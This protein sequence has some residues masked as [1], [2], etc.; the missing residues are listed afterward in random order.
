MA[1]TQSETNS[2]QQP[3]SQAA[4]MEMDYN[5]A[6]ELAFADENPF[7]ESPE[8]AAL[9]PNSDKEELQPS[10]ELPS[11]PPAK[12]VNIIEETRRLNASTVPLVSDPGGDTWVFIS[13]PSRQPGQDTSQYKAICDHYTIPHC[14]NSD[15]L[16][17][18]NSPAFNSWYSPTPQHRVLRRRG[19]VGK[20]PRNIKFVIDLTPQ[21][22]GDE[23]AHL[24]SELMCPHGIR[25]WI[26]AMSRWDIPNYLVGGNEDYSYVD[27]YRRSTAEGQDDAVDYMKPLLD[28]PG[29][30][31]DADEIRV[32]RRARS[33]YNEVGRA[34]D[35]TLGETEFIIPACYT[36]I[37]HHCGIER[38][39]NILVDNDP[40]LDSA[41][42][43]WTTFVMAKHLGV[44]NHVNLNNYIIRWLRS[45]DNPA[46][47]DAM[48]ELCLEM[49]DGLQNYALCRE[50]FGIL[51]GERALESEQD[52][53]TSSNG[54][55][56][57]HALVTIHGRKKYDISEAY[58]TR[59]EYAYIGFRE[60]VF[61]EYTELVEGDWIKVLPEF[62][63]LSKVSYKNLAFQTSLHNLRHLLLSYVRGFIMFALR[64]KPAF[65]TGPH[66][67][68]SEN[69]DIFPTTRFA[70][71]WERLSLR[72]R[73]LTRS[74]WILLGS[75]NLRTS[76]SNNAMSEGETWG[77]RTAQYEFHNRELDGE[78]VLEKPITKTELKELLNNCKY[79]LVAAQNKQKG[80]AWRTGENT[81]GNIIAS[82]DKRSSSST[83]D[84][85]LDK[86]QS[87]YIGNLK[88]SA[89]K[90]DCHKAKRP[91]M[92]PLNDNKAEPLQ[93][94]APGTCEYNKSLSLQIDT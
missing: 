49:A 24:L 65:I 22:E 12:I 35:A 26:L 4:Q 8:K 28:G 51:V 63:R 33:V 89:G 75:M 69:D 25:T 9:T 10:P 67:D 71:T 57:K 48:P 42:K 29:G 7:H 34:T 30:T 45:N 76:I 17:N 5:L 41:P 2:S 39:L 61:G 20:L 78:S 93:G 1:F 6:T 70:L 62:Q 94:M 47:I 74:F 92:E 50:A 84:K 16:K 14:I 54:G 38:V 46:F 21:M 55:K 19:L 53:Q 90:S 73:L 59:L 40:K 58:E 3:E 15:T 79:K 32:I 11:S 64:A 36:A 52:E 72:Q 68:R 81:V 91:K 80:Q 77:E 23:G 31:L 82:P 27:S 60:M 85:A 13:P 86:I 18:L 37:R 88:T 66:G 56:T 87:R 43:V 44:A 83:W